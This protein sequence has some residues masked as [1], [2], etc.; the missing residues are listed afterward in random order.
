MWT[1][2]QALGQHRCPFWLWNCG[3]SRWPKVHGWLPITFQECLTWKQTQLWRS[4]AF[5][6]TGCFRRMSFRHSISLVCCWGRHLTHWLPHVSQLPNPGASA[7][8]VNQKAL[9]GTL[10]GRH[11]LIGVL[12]EPWSP[13]QHQSEI[14]WPSSCTSRGPFGYYSSSSR[15][16][17]VKDIQVLL[18]EITWHGGVCKG[19]TCCCSRVTGSMEHVLL[20][21]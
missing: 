6:H 19:S 7:V 14:R 21:L 5:T 20:Y 3:P 10:L 16:V 18:P 15:L 4:S 17:L 1:G 2:G 13:S 8:D 11:G 9:P 12:P